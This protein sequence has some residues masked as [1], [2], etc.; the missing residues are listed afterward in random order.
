MLGMDL[1]LMFGNAV[2][3]ERVFALPGMGTLAVTAASGGVGFDLPM[4]AGIVLVVS[5]TIIVLN[6]AVD[7]IYVWLDPRIRVG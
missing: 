3:V 7:L 6:L 5:A 2:F 4:L 1:G